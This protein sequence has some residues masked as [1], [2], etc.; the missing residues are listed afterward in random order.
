M[1]YTHNFFKSK[2]SLIFQYY[3]YLYIYIFLNKHSKTLQICLNVEVRLK[4]DDPAAENRR[5]QTFVF[6]LHSTVCVNVPLRRLANE[7]RERSAWS[8]ATELLWF[9]TRGLR[10]RDLVT[11][12][13]YFLR[14]VKSV[15]ER[16]IE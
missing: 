1:L 5:I 13:F 10:P 6:T 9:C 8:R 2:I 4:S 7:N 14:F 15:I 16:V 11:V 3:V 12:Y